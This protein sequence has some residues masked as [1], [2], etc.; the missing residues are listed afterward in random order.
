ML[1]NTSAMKKHNKSSKHQKNAQIE[2]PD[3]SEEQIYEIVK[4]NNERNQLTRSKD[5][6]KRLG[7]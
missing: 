7:I 1:Q 3:Y 2:C 6:L 4:E 5:K